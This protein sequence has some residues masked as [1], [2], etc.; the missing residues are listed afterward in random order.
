MVITSFNINALPT[1]HNFHTHEEYECHYII[2]GE[3]YL[4]ISPLNERAGLKRGD[5]ILISPGQEHYLESRDS[6]K[7]LI[8]MMWTFRWEKEDY[9][10]QKD[11]SFHMGNGKI[12]HVK[13]QMVSYFEKMRYLNEAS[14]RLLKIRARLQLELFLY[15]IMEENPLDISRELEESVQCCLK[16]MYDCIRTEFSV[17]SFTEKQGIAPSQFIRNFKKVFNVTPYRYYLE[18]KVDALISYL[19]EHKVTLDIAAEKFGFSDRF[20]LSKV[21]KSVKRMSPSLYLK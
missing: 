12:I 15:S 2:D 4:A 5:F 14:S 13:E 3:G 1:K 8:Q 21:F 7:G 6:G 11:V 19:N 17:K 9:E 20:H 10:L 18:I 16:E